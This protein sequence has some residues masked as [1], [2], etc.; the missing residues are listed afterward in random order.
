MPAF[1]HEIR[2]APLARV[3]THQEAL[4]PEVPFRDAV[5]VVAVAHEEGDGQA[6]DSREDARGSPGT[7]RFGFEAR[8]EEFD[9]WTAG[10]VTGGSI[11]YQIG[12][13]AAVDA[14]PVADDVRI[15]ADQFE[16]S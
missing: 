16:G 3:A 4:A 13:I 5:D 9:V 15:R 6:L 2:R 11:E 10:P 14:Q 1:F 12:R 7:R 8:A